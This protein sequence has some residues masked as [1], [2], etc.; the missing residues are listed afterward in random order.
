MSVSIHATEKPLSKIFSNDFVFS[1]PHYQRPYA[2]TTE[3]AGDLLSDLISFL[4]NKEKPVS[5][6]NPYFLGSIV[7]IKN[8]GS[9]TSDVIDGQQRLTTLTLLLAAIR[10]LVSSDL[11]E[12]ITKYI[13]EQGNKIEGTP[14][15]YRL[16]LRERDEK[17]FRD[18]VQNEKG[19]ESLLLLDNG[20]LN[21][22]QVN[23]KTNATYFI[24]ALKQ[25]PENQRTRLLQYIMTRCFLVVVSTPDIDSAYRIFSVLNARGLDLG[26]TDLLK[27][28]IIGAIP[29]EQQ[30]KYTKIWE[31]E[32]EDLG[33]EAFQELFTHIRMISRKAKPK[34]SILNEYIK[35]IKPKENPQNFIDEILKPYSDAFQEIKNTTYYSDKNAETINSILS[36]LNQIDNADWLPPAI[37]FLSRN[38][39]CPEKL[40]KFFTDLER[41]AAGLMIMRADVNYRYDRYGRLL[42]KI[43]QELDLSSQ[44][45]P[46][47]LSNDESKQIIQALE[48]NLYQI[49]GIRKYVLLRLD[50]LLSEG[51]AT[52]NY[53]IISVEHVLP[54]NPPFN[55]VWNRWFT[56]EDKAKY[57]HKIGN[58]VLLSRKKNSQAQ[59]YDFDKKKEKYFATRN[60]ISPFAL[61]TQVLQ[62]SK[63]TPNIIEQRQTQILQ[64]LRQHWRL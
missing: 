34:E 42:A 36:W 60:G 9:P 22:S 2:W 35:Y 48:G 25:L 52:Y 53:P 11:A 24:E 47:Q 31:N 55:S 59:N 27:S 28:D 26:L 54:Q 16:T 18:Y 38:H 50:S 6:I 63:W 33:R 43:E 30:E 64:K 23:I 40:K 37:L 49:T 51:E 3:Q 15:R 46:L 62:Q 32:E 44:D 17:F 29:K 1:I 21:D 58:L 14:N 7:L 20:Q 61:T 56:A 10:S 45:S 57:V 19:L 41:L 12:D 13:Y 8:E 39:Q 4:G 5:E